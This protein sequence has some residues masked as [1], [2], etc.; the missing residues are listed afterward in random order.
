[1]QKTAKKGDIFFLS[2]YTILSYPTV[3]FKLSGFVAVGDP[4]SFG[5]RDI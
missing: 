3:F 2:L 5:F 1:M 4:V